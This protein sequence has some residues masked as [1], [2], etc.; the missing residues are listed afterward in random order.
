M[1]NTGFARLK[2]GDTQ[3]ALDD[4]ATANAF[5]DDDLTKQNLALIL[6]V[7]GRFE[8][9]RE[10][11]RKIAPPASPG[12]PVNLH[13]KDAVSRCVYLLWALAIPHDEPSLR[14]ANLRVFLKD[15]ATSQE[16]EITEDALT[17]LASRAKE[18]LPKVAQPCSDISKIESV[19]ALLGI[20][21]HPLA[22]NP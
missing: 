21:K 20:Q 12:V 22:S 8:D 13:A 18:A 15:K 5:R 4:F 9:A 7:S 16:S 14:A 6:I 2:L 19:V 1:E 11:L 17:N 10:I 3:G